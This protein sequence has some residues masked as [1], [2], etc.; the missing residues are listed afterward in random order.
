MQIK[1]YVLTNYGNFKIPDLVHFK[2]FAF[3]LMQLILSILLKHEY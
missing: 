2:I 3:N 1:K